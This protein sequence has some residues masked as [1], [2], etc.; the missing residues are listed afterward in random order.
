MKRALKRLLIS[1]VATALVGGLLPT[2]AAADPPRH[3]ERRYDDRHGSHHHY[4]PRGHTVRVLPQH[5]QRVVV[6]GS[7]YF[8]YG[9]SFYRPHGHSFVVVAAPLG[10]LVS[11]LP[12]GY[13]SLYIGGVPYYYANQTYYVW[14][15]RAPGY[16]VVEEPAGTDAATTVPSDLFVYPK[17]G[18]SEEQVA[19]DRYECHRWAV[20]ETGYDPSAGSPLSD[21]ARAEY[22]RAMSAC[23]E[24]RSYSV[25]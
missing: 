2:T 5:H 9:G 15:R 11:L 22:H 18:Q 4:E 3:A 16:R 20:K 24:A 6:R 19:Q 17:A 1:I 10:A 14:D 13:A 23:L 8:Y 12:P 25:K 7:P 21:A